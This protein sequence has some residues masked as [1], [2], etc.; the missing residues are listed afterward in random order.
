[1]LPLDTIHAVIGYLA[2]AAAPTAAPPRT[3]LPNHHRLSGFAD[4]LPEYTLLV[5]HDGEEPDAPPGTRRMSGGAVAIHPEL[6]DA[7]HG[8]LVDLL[9][10]FAGTLQPPADEPSTAGARVPLDRQSVAPALTRAIVPRPGARLVACAVLYDDIHTEPSTGHDNSPT[11]V[12]TRRVDA[13]DVDGRVY[14]VVRQ[15]DRPDAV[16][17]VDD[18]PDVLDTP[19]TY[20]GLTALI[21]AA[22]HLIAAA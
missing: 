9:T 1:M 6:V 19:A 18:E 20:A 4:V 10:D 8:G 15:S 3:E 13:V 17:L 7:Y 16:I 5:L 22:L 11:I 14:Q 21:T 2:T 12:L